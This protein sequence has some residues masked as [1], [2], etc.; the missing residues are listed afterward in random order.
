MPALWPSIPAQRSEKP[1]PARPGPTPASA[2]ADNAFAAFGAVSCA[3]SRNPTGSGRW[4]AVARGR[5]RS[6]PYFG[7]AWAWSGVLCASW[8]LRDPNT[9]YGPF[10]VRTASPMLV[11]GTTL[12]PATPYQGAVVTANRFPGAG[13]LTVRGYGHT[14]AAVPS[15][16]VDRA[17][18][19]YLLT[20]TLPRRG[21]VCRQR[22]LP[23]G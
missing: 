13:L 22:P 14:S 3:D 1:L 9:Y 6:Y 16:C 19:A 17:V 21:A 23:F 18:T 12:D 20:T 10:G 11:I 7:R 4:A 8:S 2:P 5:D 15:A